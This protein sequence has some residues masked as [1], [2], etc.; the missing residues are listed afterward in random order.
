MMSRS[1]ATKDA[2]YHFGDSELAA[3][4]LGLLAEV[5][6]SSSAEFL[7]GLGGH[8]PARILDAGCGCGHTTRLLA[9][10]FPTA[11]VVGVDNSATFIQRASSSPHQRIQFREADV[12]GDFSGGPY[13]LVYA[14]YLLTHLP[15]AF[16]VV[17]SWAHALAP[18][19]LIALQE[20]E[21]IETDESVFSNYLA[22]VESMLATA[23]KNLYI[24]RR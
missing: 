21:W 4:R 17:Q 6:A 15:R 22:I 23:G 14:R 9:E 11:L 12:T 16:E 8:A 10:V 24:G 5:F 2:N 7:A 3:E 18:E 20:N 19:G 1:A 13:D